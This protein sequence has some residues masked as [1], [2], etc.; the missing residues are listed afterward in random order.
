MISSALSVEDTKAKERGR[1]MELVPQL[2]VW[3]EESMPH[4]LNPDTLF[5]LRHLEF[6]QF[7]VFFRLVSIFSCSQRS[8]IATWAGLSFFLS[9]ILL[10]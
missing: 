2:L 9:F 6:V 5:F 8:G 10:Y 4:I 7:N 1:E 3:P